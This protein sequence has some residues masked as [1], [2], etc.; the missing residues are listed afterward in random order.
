MGFRRLGAEMVVAMV[1]L[2]THRAGAEATRATSDGASQQGAQPGPPSAEP[3][4]A[5]PSAAAPAT[6]AP[7][8]TAPTTTAPTTTAPTTTAPT[9]TAPTTTAPVASSITHES[10]ESS[11]SAA[12]TEAE[13]E[14]E[15]EAQ[16]NF[17]FGAQIG[18]YNPNGL[19]VR[20]GARAISLE[21]TAGFVPYLLSYGSSQHPELKFVFPFEVTPQL[22]IHAVTF[23]NGVSGAALLGYRYNV[24]LGHGTTLGGQIEKRIS[25]KLVAEG[26]LGF[27]YYPDASD[28]L[29]GH[30]VPKDTSFN[31]PPQISEGITIGLLFYP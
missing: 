2:S 25:R 12:E 15:A 11:A 23:K 8:T 22:V 26:M 18:F 14:A 30:Q 3:S 28:R 6:T 5:P 31:F 20:A 9:T 10:D 16:D 29:R 13:A 7:T 19:T 4:A 27:S 17:G 24:D 1:L 21:L